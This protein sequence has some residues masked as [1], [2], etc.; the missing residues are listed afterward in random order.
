MF[1]KRAFKLI[2]LILTALNVQHVLAGN[3]TDRGGGD[4]ALINDQVVLADPYFRRSDVEEG[5][6]GCPQGTT[7]E[8][9]PQLKS[10]LFAVGDILLRFGAKPGLKGTAKFIEEHVLSNA[11]Y[12]F[13][14]ELPRRNQPLPADAPA[15]ASIEPI[16]YTEGKLTF[17]RAPLFRRM[18][19]REQAKFIVHE[20]LHAAVGNVK[21]G[22][23]VDV[24]NGIETALQIQGLQDVGG[25]PYLSSSD[26]DRLDRMRRTLLG[27]GI[28]DKADLKVHPNG[29]ATYLS[30]SFIDPTAYVGIRMSFGNSTW[31]GPKAVIRNTQFVNQKGNYYLFVGSNIRLE[32][33]AQLVWAKITYDIDHATLHLGPHARIFNSQIEGTRWHIQSTIQLGAQAKIENSIILAEALSLA[34]KSSLEKFTVSVSYQSKFVSN[35][36]INKVGISMSLGEGSSIKDLRLRASTAEELDFITEILLALDTQPKDKTEY[37]MLE[38]ASGIHG[39]FGGQVKE[40][41]YSGTCHVRTHAELME[42]VR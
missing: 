5:L 3:G 2:L 20:R 24:T 42:L 40:I 30:K 7:G 22:P 8:L 10:E 18:T 16:G 26:L 14:E 15:E 34:S 17:I 38:I 9:A 1:A 41:D 23:I 31:I 11:L 36:M 6:F 19:L 39:D 29:G 37:P 25:T 21:Y 28:S 27:T 32:E 4:V 33:G 35:P 12:C 13:V